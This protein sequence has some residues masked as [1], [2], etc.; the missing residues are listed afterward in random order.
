MKKLTKGGGVLFL[1]AAIVAGV[2]IW[3]FDRHEPVARLRLPDGMELRLEYV[4]Y[5]TEHRMPGA[6]H[7]LGW[8]SGVAERW[9]LPG[10]RSKQPEY[11]YASKEPTLGL[12]FTQFDPKSGKFLPVDD[13]LTILSARTR[14]EPAGQNEIFHYDE[15]GHSPP[16]PHVICISSLYDRRAENLELEVSMKGAETTFVVPN[17]AAKMEFPVWRPE[18]V[19]QT[20]RIGEYDVVLRSLAVR[21]NGN[22]PSGPRGERRLGE[23]FAQTEFEILHHGKKAKGLKA[24]EGIRAVDVLLLDAT[25]NA[26]AEDEPPPLSEPAWKVRATVIRTGDYPFAPNEGVTMGPVPMPAEGKYEILRLPAAEGKK[27][28]RL[29][30]LLGPGNYVWREEGFVQARK[31]VSVQEF[32]EAMAAT[33]TVHTLV[34]NTRLPALVLLYEQDDARMPEESMT[35]AIAARLH[36]GGRS[37]GLHDDS[38]GTSCAWLFNDERYDLPNFYELVDFDVPAPPPGTPVSLQ[39][40]PVKPESVDFIVAPPEP[41]KIPAEQGR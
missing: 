28:L 7:L 10:I 12:W 30:A 20:R 6:G 31:V 39:I 2:A 34:I 29:A 15:M 18:P 9:A 13:Q 38:D 32:E 41:E 3:L 40:V 25:G 26:T 19:P 17:P 1:V 37:A 4:T 36:W 16:V 24:I 11:L 33:P 8:A 21:S 27:S 14:S 35:P 22:K 23:S 5:G